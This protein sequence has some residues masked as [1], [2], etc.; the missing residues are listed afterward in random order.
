MAFFCRRKRRG[1][2]RVPEPDDV[3]RPTAFQ[4]AILSYEGMD[5]FEVAGSPESVENVRFLTTMGIM[6][7]DDLRLRITP[8]G[9]RFVK[10]GGRVD[11]G[12][13]KRGARPYVNL[14]APA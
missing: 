10:G 13:Q 7:Y 6:E 2:D 8:Y 5:L 9:R 1:P 4:A 11:L 12:L 14:D 3:R